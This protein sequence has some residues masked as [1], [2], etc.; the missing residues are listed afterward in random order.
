MAKPDFR[1]KKGEGLHPWHFC[2]NCKG[3]PTE[4]FESSQAKVGPLCHECEGLERRQM[5]TKDNS[6]YL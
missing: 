5:C 1:Q 4:N 3:W 2:S 6:Y